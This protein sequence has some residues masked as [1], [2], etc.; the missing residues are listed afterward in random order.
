MDG[1]VR[2]KGSGFCVSLL[3]CWTNLSDTSNPNAATRRS[4]CAI[5]AATSRLSWSGSGPTT[6]RST[7]G[8]SPRR[9]SANGS[10]T[11]RIR[12][13]CALH[14]STARSRRCGLCSAGSCARGPWSATSRSSSARSAPPSGCRPSSRRAAWRGSSGCA[15]A[16]RRTFSRSGMRSSCCCSTPAGCA[17]RS[18]WPSTATT[19]PRTSLRCG[20]AAR[21][22][23]SGW[24]QCWSLCGKKFCTISG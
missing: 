8:G 24:F 13:A 14:R 12:G 21:A 2:N 20:S 6:R 19:S 18:L 17:L 15:N 7:R 5:T 23:S 3:V 1:L 4:R 16:I 10:S 11:S 22:T 9:T